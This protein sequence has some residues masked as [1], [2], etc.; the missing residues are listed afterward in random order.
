[1]TTKLFKVFFL[2]LCSI[3][4][5]L[6][7]LTRVE[8]M[9]PGLQLFQ[10]GQTYQTVLLVQS[11]LVALAFASGLPL[12]VGSRYAERRKSVA[13]I[14]TITTALAALCITLRA[15]SLWQMTPVDL[16]APADP[17]VRYATMLY[18]C[19]VLGAVAMVWV[20][21]LSGPVR[22]VGWS[23]AI[24]IVAITAYIFAA[25]GNEGLEGPYLSGT[26]AV[27]A[28]ELAVFGTILGGGV[29]ILF[30]QSGTPTKLH[31]ALRWAHLGLI[32]AAVVT[33]FKLGASGLPAEYP[34]YPEF[35]S[36]G[37][38]RLSLL[39]FLWLGCLAFAVLHSWLRPH[40]TSEAVFT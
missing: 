19:A 13:A 10:D 23:S 9:N 4:A 25:F 8:L 32:V 36:A 26:Y 16:F 11:T 1:M 27:T 18:G 34:D 20:G 17:M 37:Q 40:K 39:V 38:F 3:A 33:A 6:F 22:V 24:L 7:A 35:H 5:G 2:A 12:I 21:L 31:V 29:V 28:Y 30:A 15:Y 14:A